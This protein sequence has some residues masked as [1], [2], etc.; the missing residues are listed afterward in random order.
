MSPW[1]VVGDDSVSLDDLETA[2]AAPP[3]SSVRRPGSAVRLTR[4]YPNGHGA[5]FTFSLRRTTTSPPPRFTA[6]G[7][8]G[9]AFVT[10]ADRA[11]REGHL[12][13][14]GDHRPAASG[15]NW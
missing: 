3:R 2:L 7:S 9:H 14:V 4:R 10:R 15:P 1:I 11:I 5:P 8:G 12:S 6:R 13:V